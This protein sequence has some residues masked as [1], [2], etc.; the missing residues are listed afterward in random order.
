MLTGLLRAT[1]EGGRGDRAGEFRTCATR[2]GTPLLDRMK[3]SF[4]AKEYSRL[5]ELACLGLGVAGAQS[6]DAQSVPE[7]YAAV[8]QKIFGLAETFG[9]ADLVEVDAEGQFYP[10]AKLE[11]GPVR[12][13]L[14]KF[15]D[16]SFWAELASRL[17]ERDLRAELGATK[18]SD[19]LSD[20]EVEKLGQLEDGYWREFEANGV[21][22]IQVL[23]GGHG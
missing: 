3:V 1:D 17:A 6:D 8:T 19:E 13:K 4:S 20:E 7:R 11:E 10:S 21:D 12:E 22:H 16:E 15:V 2:R 14:E 5:L 23:R 18:L 9:C